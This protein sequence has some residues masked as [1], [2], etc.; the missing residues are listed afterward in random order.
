[1]NCINKFTILKDKQEKPG[2]AFVQDDY[3]AGYRMESLDTGD[4]TLEGLEDIFTIERKGSI[5]EFAQNLCGPDFKRFE[6]ELIRLKAMP[7]S[8][9]VCEFN[10]DQIPTFPWS[11]D[12][13]IF[14]K[15]KIRV[16]GDYL[17]K[18]YLEVQMEYRVPIIF[19]GGA[20]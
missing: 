11:T 8:Y 5:Q 7:H 9:I 17:M 18:R 10:V 2:F 13:P 12:L 14:V 1:M 15:K 16:K 19:A 6:K 4:Y 3:C 20:A